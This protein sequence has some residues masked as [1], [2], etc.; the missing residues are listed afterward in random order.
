MAISNSDNF[1]KARFACIVYAYRFFTIVV[2]F[3]P[4]S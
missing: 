3:C 1:Y 4:F 2:M